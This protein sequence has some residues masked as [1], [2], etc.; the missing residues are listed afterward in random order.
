LVDSGV[1][2]VLGSAGG[3]RVADVSTATTSEATA[4]RLSELAGAGTLLVLGPW[5]DT[6]RLAAD[7]AFHQVSPGTY[8]TSV[9]LALADNWPDWQRDHDTVVLCDTEP[10]TGEGHFAVLRTDRSDR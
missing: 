3:L 7:V 6:P 10:R 4:H 5:V 1:M 8:C 2:L 9:W